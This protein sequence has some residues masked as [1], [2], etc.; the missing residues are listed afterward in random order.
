[1]SSQEQENE[2]DW[3]ETVY[4][5]IQDLL[6]RWM[7]ILWV[8]IASALTGDLVVS[9]IYTPMYS[10]EATFVMKLQPWEV[11]EAETVEIAEAFDYILKSNIFL[12]R[13][14]ENIGVETLNGSYTSEI[15]P[16]TNMIK[17]KAVADGPRLTY[18]MMHSMM[19]NYMDI[20]RQVIGDTQIEVID[21][22]KIPKAPYNQ[23]S[24]L[25]NLVFFGGVGAGG[26][27]FLI[28]LLSYIKDTVKGKKDVAGKLQVHL[29]GSIAVE[30]K[31]YFRKG[32]FHRKKSILLT[33]LSTSFEFVE[34]VKKIRSRVE[35]ISRNK[36][37]KIIM[38][39]SSAENEGKSSIIGNLAL[40]LAN[41]GHRVLVA[42]MDFRKPAIYK[43]MNQVENN[44]I[45]EV[46]KEE[47]TWREAVVH[48]KRSRIDYL[49]K[50]GYE[51]DATRL[52][53]SP[54]LKKILL[55]M[56]E[57]YDYVLL[58]SA[59]INCM[60]D[61][62]L[63][64]KMA[65][66]VLLVVRQNYALVTLVNRAISKIMVTKTPI[67]GAVLNRSKRKKTKNRNSSD[68]HYRYRR[69]E[70]DGK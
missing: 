50:Y 30:S 63:L 10:A 36:G 66:T 17:I 24:H 12:K 55:E 40:A 44:G 60:S 4:N 27:I 6:H 51:D 29:L 7:L 62:V 45:V 16:G 70:R 9:L 37:Y 41:N 22:L 26:M 21:Q 43:V 48:E 46:I 15:I 61:A 35:R 64:S 57:E 19:K 1:M 13:V 53:E 49:L 5:I 38:V 32:R 8:G 11:D 14:R 56:R 3:G 67:M 68:A 39:T 23:L 59:P 18:L 52:L 28:A 69:G 33:Q 54:V 47:K 65:D 58:D 2:I 20:S 42:D 31:I 34:E 25:K